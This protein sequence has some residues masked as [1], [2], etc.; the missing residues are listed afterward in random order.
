VHARYRPGQLREHRDA[1]IERLANLLEI[2]AAGL[3]HA[4]HAED[5]RAVA[6]HAM[7]DAVLA[8]LQRL[9]EQRLQQ[10]RTFDT[11]RRAREPQRE[12]LA[13]LDTARL[14]SFAG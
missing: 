10:L 12:D 3:D 9:G 11:L 1:G 8:V 5:D 14:R 4:G 6:V 7:K 13:P 2:E